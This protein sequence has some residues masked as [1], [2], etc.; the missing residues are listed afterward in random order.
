MAKSRDVG[1]VLAEALKKA[2]EDVF[3]MTGKSINRVPEYFLSVKIAEHLHQH[4]E[5]FTFSMEEQVQS[6]VKELNI[7]DSNEE[8]CFRLN[9]K[10]DLVLRHSK[11]GGVKH[12]VELKRTIGVNGIHKDVLRLAWICANTPPGHR[13]E[14]NFL[15]AVSNRPESLFN[16]RTQDIISWV[17][18]E[19]GDVI[20]VKFKR[21]D[22]SHLENTNPNSKRKSLFGG[23]W[24]LKYSE[25]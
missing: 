12:I 8:D 13:A 6:L 11:K 19:F 22:L 25:S 2:S 23:V 14:K 1:N 15:V 21:V 18:E 24:E 20:T 5:T 9:G 16:T 3:K 10:V 7:D 4:F 17:N